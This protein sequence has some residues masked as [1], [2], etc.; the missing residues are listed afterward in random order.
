MTT[1]AHSSSPA[2]SSG[3]QGDVTNSSVQSLSSITVQNIS[4]MVATKL[5]RHNY[6]TWRSL[7]LPVLKRFKLLGLVTGSD[8]CPSQVLLDSSGSRSL[9]PAYEAWCERDQILMIWINSTLSEDLLPLTEISDK[10]AAAGEPIS[11]S[12]LVA[13]T[14]SGLS[15]EYESFIDSIETRLEPVNSDELHGILG[16]V[17][18][19]RSTFSGSQSANYSSGKSF[20]CQLCLKYGHDAL[21]CEK[22]SQFA[23]QRSNVGPPFGMTATTSPPPSYWLTDSGASHHVTPD[24]ASLNSAIPYTGS[25][26]LFV[27]NGKGLCISHTGSALIRTPNSTFQLNDVLL[28]PKASHNLLSVY[29]FVYDNWASLTF[30]PF[31]FY[32]KD[33]RTGRMLFQGPCEGGL[34]P[35]YWDASNGTSGVALSPQALLVHKADIHLWHQRLGHPSSQVLHT[36]VNKHQ[37]PVIPPFTTLSAPLSPSSL[38]ASSPHSSASVPAPPPSLNSHPMITRA[39]AGIHKPKVFT[40]TKHSLPVSVDSLACLPP[41]PTTFL[42]ASKNPHWMAAMKDEFHALQSTE[43]ID[44]S[45]TFSPVAKPTTIRILLSIAISYDWFIHQLD[46]S[47]AFLHGTLKEAVY[48]TQPPGFVDSTKP[49]HVCK[50]NRSLYGLKQAPRACLFIK[51][52]SSIT[53]ILVYVDDIIITGSSRSVCQSIIAQ[54]QTMFPVK[55]LGDIHYF[56]GIEVH[57]SAKGM[58]LHQSK[59]ALDLLKKTDMLGVKP[60]STPYMHSPR[61]IHLQAVKRILRYLKGTLDAGLWFTPG[62]QRLTAWSDADW[63]G[64]PVDRR[65]TSGYCVF[66]G[67]NLISWSAKK[68]CTVARS[69]TEAEYRSLANTAAELSWVCKI[70][71]DI[72]FPI[73]HTPAIFCDNQSAIALAFNPVFHARTKHVEID[74]HYIREKVLA[75]QVS[76]HH[77][78]SLLQLADIFTKSLPSARFA[79]LTSKLSVRF[80]PFSLRGERTPLVTEHVMK[81]HFDLTLMGERGESFRS[82][83][84]TTYFVRL[85]L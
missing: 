45:E 47:N 50:L 40:A 75:G 26:H 20:Q 72:S 13:Y 79:E 32:I 35:F 48:M 31:G 41:T 23:S 66:L 71:Q 55:D 44:F 82:K 54:L 51:Q 78:A 25:D 29:K 34:Y 19:P 49:R 5:N 69:S 83:N 21:N 18:S 77:V 61:T 46:V 64:C 58:F 42:Q 68:Q 74:Y 11:E 62:S 28:V 22:L 39:K 16:P 73:L 17:P 38:P 7:F 14:L 12:D 65:S 52:D 56:L 70:L 53:F 15:D 59:Y 9:N 80:P 24:P 76:V 60:C 6:I 67:P 4:G 81:V 33:L 8:V 84:R 63:A 43:G 30:D 85:R 37:L 1:A 57:R 3:S 10:L 27:G 2:A 36:I